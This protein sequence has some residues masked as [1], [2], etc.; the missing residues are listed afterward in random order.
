MS[1][2]HTENEPRLRRI[3]AIHDISGLGKCSLTVA[4]P[5]ISASGV[6]CSCI[7]TALLSTHTGE[8]EGYTFRDLSDE[9]LPIAAHWKSVGA[10]FDGIY[11]GYLASAEQAGTLSHV[12]ELLSN[13][14]T[15]IIVDPV[16]GDNGSYYSKMGPHMRDAFRNLC[17]GAHVI[18]PNITEAAFLTDTPY[19]SGPHSPSY[20]DRLLD[21][22]SLICPGTVVITGVRRDESTVGVAALDGRTGKRFTSMRPHGEGVF[23]GAGDIFASALAALTV[24]G[25]SLETAV[26]AAISLVADCV[27]ITSQSSRPRRFGMDFELALPAYI[28]SVE[29]LGLS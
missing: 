12:I 20:I 4:L 2:Q 24:R 23:Y 5:V 21:K 22:L 27:E 19:D 25:A 15:K 13:R 6:E 16:M 3:A 7:P 1:Q 28:K 14:D 26:D 8:F 18:T 11:S 29:A 9:I 17:A 10:R